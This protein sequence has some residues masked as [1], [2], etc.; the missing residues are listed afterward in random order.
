MATAENVPFGAASA[1]LAEGEQPTAVE[2]QIAANVPLP[3]WRP[4]HTPPAELKP[5]SQ[6]VL[7]ALASTDDAPAIASDVN[8]P[9]PSARP[10][11]MTVEAALAA[12][13]DIPAEDESAQDE[14]EVAS[15]APAAGAAFGLRPARGNC[16]RNS[17]S[18][19]AQE[20]DRHRLG[21][22]RPCRGRRWQRQDDAQVGPPVGS[23]SQAGSQGRGRLPLRPTPHAGAL[24]SGTQVTTVTT[25]TKAPGFAYNMVRT[26][27]TEVYTAGFQQGDQSASAHK[28]SGTAVKFLSVARFSTN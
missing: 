2:Q 28:F 7:M 27:P 11:D 26:A 1:P 18:C 5:E 20:R 23:G 15:L 14:L 21:R 10:Q 3:T 25:N 4:N 24:R 12:A 16:N 13:N 22:H 17:C 8:A 9:L 6:N 19:N